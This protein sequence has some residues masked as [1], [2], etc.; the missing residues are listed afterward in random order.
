[1]VTRVDAHAALQADP[2]RFLNSF[3]HVACHGPT[4]GLAAFGIEKLRETCFRFFEKLAARRCA[5]SK[6]QA[7]ACDEV[8]ASRL[9]KLGRG[10]HD[11]G[12]E[13]FVDSICNRIFQWAV[14]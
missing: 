1:M 6:L 9:S 5:Y 2:Q 13:Y 14:H 8:D 11:Y 3:L 12:I 10:V 4:A 7:E